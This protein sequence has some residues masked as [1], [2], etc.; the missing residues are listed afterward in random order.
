M[1]R[2]SSTKTACPLAQLRAVKKFKIAVFSNPDRK[3]MLHQV[4]GDLNPASDSEESCAPEISYCTLGRPAK[5]KNLHGKIGRRVDLARVRYGT[6]VYI[7]QSG[8][9]VYARWPRDLDPPLLHELTTMAAASVAA[10]AAARRR[11][12]SAAASTKRP[13]QQAEASWFKRITRSVRLTQSVAAGHICVLQQHTVCCCVNRSSPQIPPGYPEIATFTSLPA[14][15][16]FVAI[17]SDLALDCAG[18][19]P[20]LM[21]WNRG[22]NSGGPVAQGGRPAPLTSRYQ[23][24]TIHAHL[25][26]RLH[27]IAR[28][29]SIVEIGPPWLIGSY[30]PRFGRQRAGEPPAAER[31][32]RRLPHHAISQGC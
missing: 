26:L 9:V 1:Y 29:L 32:R 19:A 12:Q 30:H 18:Y 15:W 17:G 10:S 4:R 20:R 22:A 6:I 5:L 7:S 11:R 8:G 31:D 23:D 14:S 21:V 13:P 28:E 27:A 24:H 25:P 3:P 16:A 2:V